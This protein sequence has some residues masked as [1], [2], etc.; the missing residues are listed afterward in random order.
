MRA[1]AHLGPGP[2]PDERTTREPGGLRT[3]AGD[4]VPRRTTRPLETGGAHQPDLI[5]IW[6][7]TR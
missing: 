2:Q 5:P 3:H 7:A 6:R 1:P 4:V